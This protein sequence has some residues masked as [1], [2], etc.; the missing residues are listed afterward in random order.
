MTKLLEH[1]VD[2]VRAL[3]PAM[4][5]DVARLLLQFLGEDQPV[6]PLT[7][8]EAASFAESR[9]QASRREFATDEQVR[10]VWAK[11]GL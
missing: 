3:P 6:I 11:H 9:A 4:Q 2:S 8:E 5:D 1:A 7:P 10:S